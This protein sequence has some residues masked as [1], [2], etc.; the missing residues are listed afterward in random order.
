[1][2]GDNVLPS[3]IG[4]K[5]PPSETFKTCIDC[6]TLDERCEKC[7]NYKKEKST[8]VE[9]PDFAK[10]MNYKFGSCDR[11]RSDIMEAD[12]LQK[13]D[14]PCL[15]RS[16]N[17]T[18]CLQSQLDKK[19]VCLVCE[20]GFYRNTTSNECSKCR[21]TYSPKNGC[22]RCEKNKCLECFQ[23]Y[24][25]QKGR[26][27]KCTNTDE[28]EN[29]EFVKNRCTACNPEDNYKCSFCDVGFFKSDTGQKCHLKCGVG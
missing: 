10:K 19:H 5:N 26:C 6:S 17:Q 29:T 21:S 22:K 4:L 13:E 3:I 27:T 7:A 2:R 14:G 16:G 20:T 11:C 15:L 24:I 1:M 23:G 18:N 9:I 12:E 25:L 8:D 28:D